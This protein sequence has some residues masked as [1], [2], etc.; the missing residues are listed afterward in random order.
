MS[1][2]VALNSIKVNKP[3]CPYCHDDIQSDDEKAGCNQCMAWFHEECWQEH[4]G[5]TSCASPT[6][7]LPP[8]EIPR[9]QLTSNLEK[10]S[11]HNRLGY[12]LLTAEHKKEAAKMGRELGIKAAG[13][14]FLLTILPLGL[15]CLNAPVE[16]AVQFTLL[17]W[18]A[19]LY[20]V[21]H[22]AHGYKKQSIL[23]E[24]LN[25]I[26]TERNRSPS[27]TP[28]TVSLPTKDLKS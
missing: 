20:I 15:A 5:C 16:V 2:Q 1:E 27:G 19:F 14:A 21:Y 4:G 17:H 9:G 24:S 6:Q 13:I 23:K 22:I 8:P 3:R 11:I 18:P 7:P 25:E 28:R 10:P 26:I 12:A